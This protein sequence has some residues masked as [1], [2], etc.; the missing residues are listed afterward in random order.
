MCYR[1]GY[2]VQCFH[3]TVTAAKVVGYGH[4]PVRPLVSAGLLAWLLIGQP[5]FRV[6]TISLPVS[7]AASLKYFNCG[8]AFSFRQI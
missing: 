5:S 3:Y 8:F 2:I 6:R 1:G 4:Q 7:L